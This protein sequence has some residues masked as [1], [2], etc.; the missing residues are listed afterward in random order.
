MVAKL[1]TTC[2]AT[3]KMA[4]VHQ[5]KDTGS[6]LCNRH[7]HNFTFKVYY[8]VTCLDREQEFLEVISK[9]K[10]LIKRC[11]RT[12]IEFGIEFIDF[13]GESCEQIAHSILQDGK[14]VRVEVWEDDECGAIC[15]WHTP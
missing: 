4:G 5:W 6:F 13:N 15:E 14:F 3:F 9:T 12:N 11:W 8:D 7:R 1:K 2:V 10:N